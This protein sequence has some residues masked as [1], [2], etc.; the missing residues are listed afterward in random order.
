[1]TWVSFSKKGRRLPKVTTKRYV[2]VGNKGFLQ[3]I[4]NN[5][6]WVYKYRNGCPSVISLGRLGCNF[7]GELVEGGDP[8]GGFQY[9]VDEMKGNL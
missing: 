6:G 7:L 3:Y 5:L 1:V 4:K 9:E 8:M 2:N